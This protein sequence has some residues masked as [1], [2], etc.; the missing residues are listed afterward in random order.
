MSSSGKI[1]G[2]DIVVKNSVNDDFPT[3]CIDGKIFGPDPLLCVESG[4]L[5]T[6]LLENNGGSTGVMLS[7]K[8]NQSGLVDIAGNADITYN[9]YCPTDPSTGQQSITGCT[10]T[11]ASQIIYYYI[12]KYGLDLA[13]TLN[14]DDAYTSNRNSVINIKADGSTP[15]TISFA[16][17][18]SKLENFDLQSA[19]DIAALNYACGVI[20][21]ANYSSSATS[22]SWGTEL[23]Y[24]S[25]FDCAVIVY[26]GSLN[27]WYWGEYDDSDKFRISDEGYEVLIENLIAGR[28]V[29]VSYPGHAL[30]LDGYNAADDTFHINFGWGGRDNGWFTREELYQ[31]Q[32]YQ[33]VYDLI[34]DADVNLSVTDSSVYGSGTFIRALEQANGIIGANTISFN[35]SLV[36][37]DQIWKNYFIISDETLISNMNLDVMVVDSTDNSWGIGFWLLPEEN[38]AASAE[39]EKFS[40]SLI[41]NTSKS[42][43]AAFYG[44]AFSLDFSGGLVYTGKYAVNSDYSRGAETVLTQLENWQS[45][46]QTI[47]SP[48]LDKISGYLIYSPSTVQTINIKDRSFISGKIYAGSGSVVNID[49]SSM[50]YTDLYSKTV[51]NIELLASPQTDPIISVINNGSNFYYYTDSLNIT[52]TSEAA[53]TYTLLGPTNYQSSLNNL[54]V[55]ITRAAG[56]TTEVLNLNKAN[57]LTADGR[58][59]LLNDNG[60]LKLEVASMISSVTTSTTAPTNQDVAVTVQFHESAV[61]KK[62][63][64][65]NGDWQNY[66]GTFSVSENTTVYFQAEDAAGCINTGELIINNIDKEPP[67]IPTVR[68]STSV[69]DRTVIVS[70]VFSGDTVTGEYSFDNDTWKKYEEDIVFEENGVV[71]FRGKDAAGNISEVAAYYVRDID[72]EPPEIPVAVLSTTDPTDA[73]VRVAVSF[74]NDSVVKQYKIGDGEWQNYI[75]VFTVSENNTVYLR[76]EDLYGNACTGEVVITNIDNSPPGVPES[77]SVNISNYNAKIVWNDVSDN[78]TAGVKG[79]Y[80]RYGTSANLSGNGVFVSGSGYSLS[81]L[82]TKTYYYQIKTVDHAGNESGWSA[83]QSFE[84]KPGLVQNLQGDHNS[85]TWDL[86][87]GVRR[88]IVE[89]SGDDFVSIISLQ[90]TKNR[91]DSFALPGGTYQWRV[92][93]VGGDVFTPVEN[94]V[95]PQTEST[96][97]LTSNANGYMDIFF[98]NPVGRWNN[99]YQAVHRGSL[100]GWQGTGDSVGLSGKNKIADIFEGSTDANVLLLTDGENGDALFAD[101]IFSAAQDNLNLTQAR[102]ANLDEIR[103][104]AG[105]DIVD[106][107]SQRFAYVGDGVTIY[108]GDGDDVIW[109]NKGDNKLFGDAGN[110]HIVGASGNDVIVGGAGDDTLHGGGGDDIFCFGD[111]WGIDTVEQLSGGTVTLWFEDGS[112]EN[113]NSNTRTYTDGENTVTVNGTAD[114]TLKFGGDI[115]SLP[116]GIFSNAVTKKIFE[117]TLA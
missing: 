30:V 58:I 15:G 50:L 90:T 25:G 74:S 62:F 77:F 1:F 115:S 70:A 42:N 13:L 85:L 64:I 31:Q 28:V 7:T 81:G 33:F 39:F 72:K 94:I 36:G 8:W 60:S 68:T 35:D 57:T 2:D 66:T 54:N 76:A 52:V 84:V 32:Y 114:V 80:I 24:R 97:R 56:Q 79:Y 109:S 12:E 61:V 117:S 21:Q 11:A 59:R 113:W 19:D 55:S 106:M 6:V 101:D 5:S 67:E 93:T 17:I 91:I 102:I 10:N 53:G 34:L 26:A 75:G 46:G 89:Y 108:G 41:V 87:P 105:D 23:F 83:T 9:Y 40:G 107:T 95:A 73:D 63:R 104:G 116:D 14:A 111:D 49:S 92:K 3:E 78:G 112:K 98:A 47:D 18:N 37:A 45:H 48:I 44:D 103:A 27:S 82:A 16:A 88:Y 43:I 51:F 20:N 22:T 38:K 100:N 110:D 69:A 99:F 29:G 96:R 86:I 65:G 4:D 71:Y